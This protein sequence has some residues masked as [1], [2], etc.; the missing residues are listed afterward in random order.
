MS[1]R[2]D[3]SLSYVHRIHVLADVAYMS[4]PWK[5]KLEVLQL[6]LC[7]YEFLRGRDQLSDYEMHLLLAVVKICRTRGIEFSAVTNDYPE[8][9]KELDCF[10]T[11]YS[12]KKD[13]F[14]L[15]LWRELYPEFGSGLLGLWALIQGPVK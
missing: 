13:V 9:E 14:D 15:E 7:A 10:Q 3:Q 12:S 8:L 6:K 11:N 1:F 2:E 5:H 4:M